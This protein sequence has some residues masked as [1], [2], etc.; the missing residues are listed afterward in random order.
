MN[1]IDILKDRQIKY[2]EAGKDYQI[3]CLNPEHE[4][5]NPSMR[6]DKITGI[7]H[8]FSC[9]HKGNLFQKFGAEPNQLDMDISRLLNQ[10][11]DI[12]K[13]NNLL[14][15]TDS[16]SFDKDYRGISAYTYTEAH[17]F[18]SNQEEEFKDR[19]MFPLYDARGNIKVFAGRALHSDVESKYLFYPKGISP[20]IFPPYPEIWKNS[21]IIVEGIFDVL[22]LNDKG[23][24]NVITAF[25]THTLNKSYQEKLSHF[26]I[27]G[28]N[29]FYIMFDGDKAGQNAAKKLEK[30]LKDNGFNAETIDLPEDRDPGDLT[31]PEVRHLMRLVYGQKDSSS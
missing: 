2:K 18:T 6:V 12:S 16:V 31:E 21:L 19:L 3:S 8:C 17:A 26:Q 14:M 4:D 7:Y 9:G 1:V 24:Y 28:V 5:S 25:G 20:P 27:L 22:N 15:P 30:I 13:N 10:L 29:K 11:Q 23:C